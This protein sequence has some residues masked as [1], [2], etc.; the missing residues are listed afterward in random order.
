MAGGI[1]GENS[2]SM[3][4]WSTNCAYIYDCV[5]SGTVTAMQSLA[6]PSV[7]DSDQKEDGFCAAGGIAGNHANVALIERCYNT[8]SVSSDDSA[9]GI[10]GYTDD[11]M[12]RNWASSKQ[13]YNTLLG[14]IN[15]FNTGSVAGKEY[16]GGILGCAKRN[17]RLITCLNIGSISTGQYNGSIAGHI[18]NIGPTDLTTI[19][20]CYYA[21]DK[22]LGVASGTYTGNAVGLLEKDLCDKNAFVGFDFPHVWT[23]TPE[24]RHPVLWINGYLSE[25]S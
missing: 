14:V 21:E 13:Y 17:I 7:S 16:A 6:T 19:E 3:P 23:I 9:G 1:C 12:D 22:W 8:G 11:S 24:S 20:Y 5:N 25:S 10:V 15:C 2:L 4:F 18:T